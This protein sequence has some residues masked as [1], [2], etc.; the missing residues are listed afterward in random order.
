MLARNLLTSVLLYESV[1]TTRRRAKVVQPMVDRVMRIVRTQD[2]KNAIRSLNQVLC[3]KNASKKVME[4]L[5]SRFQDRVSGYTR[6]KPVGARKGD[7]AELVE[8]SFV[9]FDPTKMQATQE[10]AE[11]KPATKATK[12]S[13]PEKTTES[14]SASSTK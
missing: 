9:D 8:I 7:G 6:I 4:V 5:K 3:D 13:A 14:S 1:R 2:A 10:K 11:K 12:K